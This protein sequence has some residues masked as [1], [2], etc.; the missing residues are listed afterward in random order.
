MKIRDDGCPSSVYV[1]AYYNTS[2]YT[3]FLL[4]NGAFHAKF[5]DESDLL[6]E[7][8]QIIYF[9]KEKKKSIIKLARIN[10]INEEIK[11]KYN[12]V[13]ALIKKIKKLKM[14]APE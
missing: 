11:I 12:H 10:D 14:I 13:S 1:M 6:L 4:S 8:E 9:N 3:M 2:H 5:K 7:N